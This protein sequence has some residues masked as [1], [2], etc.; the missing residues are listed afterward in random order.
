MKLAV[1]LVAI[2]LLAAGVYSYFS[3]GDKNNKHKKNSRKAIRIT[4]VVVIVLLGILAVVMHISETVPDTQC[5]TTHTATSPAPLHLSTA[6][7]YFLQGDYDYEI[8]NCKQA[9]TDYTTAI[10]RDPTLSQAYNNRAYTNMRMQDYKD[11]LPDLDKAIALNPNYIQALMN[12]GDIHN[13]YY[14]IDRQ[15]AIADYEKVIA[16]GGGRSASV[17]GHLFLAK[18]NGWNLGTVFA[19]PQ[20]IFATCKGN[21]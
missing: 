4:T 5:T 12:R 15:S 14:A 6:M 1:S 2:A 7:D 9:I 19:L 16:L 21:R 8:G 13:Y 20:E 3:Q 18:H 10:T 11:A 17:C